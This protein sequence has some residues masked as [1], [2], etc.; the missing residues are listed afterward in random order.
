MVFGRMPE[1]LIREGVRNKS[2]WFRAGRLDF[3][4]SQTSRQSKVRDI[5]PPPTLTRQ[6]FV[7]AMKP[8]HEIVPETTIAMTRFQ[9]LLRRLLAWD[10]HQCVAIAEIAR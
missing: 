2:D 6:K 7:K 5:E 9:D 10:P 4:N 1:P 3:P 8:L